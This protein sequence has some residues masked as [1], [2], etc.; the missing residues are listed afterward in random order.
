MGADAVTIRSTILYTDKGLSFIELMFII[1]ITAIL[2]AIA[3]PNIVTLV[4]QSS[5]ADLSRKAYATMQDWTKMAILQGGA[6]LINQGTAL[7][8]SGNL[9]YQKSISLPSGTTITMAWQNFAPG[10]CQS[11]D[12]NGVPIPQAGQTC[13]QPVLNSTNSI[14]LLAFCRNGVCYGA[15]S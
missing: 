13:A 8:I 2:L 9:G 12:G 11:L 4:N 3:I 10:A 6:T 5:N 7:T 14:P 1:A 15:H